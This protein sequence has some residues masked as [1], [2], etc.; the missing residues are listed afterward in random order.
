MWDAAFDHE[1]ETYE[2]ECLDGLSVLQYL[3]YTPVAAQKDFQ[4]LSTILRRILTRETLYSNLYV[5]DTMKVTGL[6][7][8][9]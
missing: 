5:M 7:D 6:S 3:D 4:K 8:S 1:T 2:I 9:P